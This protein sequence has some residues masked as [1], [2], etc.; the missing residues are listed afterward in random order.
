MR[1]LGDWHYV[2][3]RFADVSAGITLPSY[4]YFN[5]GASYGLRGNATVDVNVLNAFQSKGLEEGNP[6]IITGAA[7]NVFLARPLLPR[8]LTTSIRYNF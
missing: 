7:A 1:L 3:E 4:N 6:R 5:F 2:A 8:R